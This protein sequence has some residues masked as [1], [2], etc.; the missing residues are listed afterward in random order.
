MT[1]GLDVGTR[2]W[3]KQSWERLSASRIDLQGQIWGKG[4]LETYRLYNED[5]YI[6]AWSLLNPNS[7]IR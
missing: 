1:I 5:G 4:C 3:T 7:T 6:L 2:P